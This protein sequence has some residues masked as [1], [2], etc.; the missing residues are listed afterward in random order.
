MNKLHIEVL[1]KF[2]LSLFI[3]L[4]GMIWGMHFISPVV[5]LILGL[6]TL[7]LVL[8]GVFVDR[9]R[10]SLK[11]VY[12]IVFLLGV[13]IYPTIGFYLSEI[14]A[15]WVLGSLL[16]TILLFGGLATYSYLSNKDFSFLGG[17]LFIALTALVGVSLVS[18]FIN[19]T[20]LHVGLAFVGVLIF[21][22]Y[23]LH[24]ISELKNRRFRKQ[25]IPWM[26]LT[27]FLDFINLFL[28]IMR[29]I[30]WVVTTFKD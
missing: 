7:P 16:V 27:L 2:V 14:G 6:M 25:D 5:A 20:A 17:F 30:W 26:V 9:L 18:I 28:D 4:I 21:S 10:E 12:I 24:D 11:Y 1:N 3:C 15:L 29:I 8:I 22:G 23:V 13:F 19:S